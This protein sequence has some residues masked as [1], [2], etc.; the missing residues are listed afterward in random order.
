[1]DSSS[2]YRSGERGQQFHGGSRELTHPYKR[3]W[4]GPRGSGSRMMGAQR[5][6][7]GTDLSGG[8]RAGSRHGSC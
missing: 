2:G 4:V 8:P 7:P 5:G 1:M 3:L 6:Q